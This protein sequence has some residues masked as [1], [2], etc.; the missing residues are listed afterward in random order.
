MEVNSNSKQEKFIF[1]TLA[2]S[3]VEPT[4]KF[5]QIRV[6]KRIKKTGA[7]KEPKSPFYELT[8]EKER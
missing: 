3:R 2:N 5:L 4:P 6:G 8:M 1:F 7:Q